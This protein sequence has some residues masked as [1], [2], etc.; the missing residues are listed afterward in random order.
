MV[1]GSVPFQV[2]TAVT[3]SAG[4]AQIGKPAPAFT[5]TAVVNG[6]FQDISLSSY[7][8]EGVYLLLDFEV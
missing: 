8:G 7:K 2:T 5:A 6:E 4:S 1:A 3:M